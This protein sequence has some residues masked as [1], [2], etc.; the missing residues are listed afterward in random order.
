M[1]RDMPMHQRLNKIGELLA[2]GAYL[3]IQKQKEE[4][5][6]NETKQENNIAVDKNSLKKKKEKSPKEITPSNN[7]LSSLPA[8]TRT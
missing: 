4:A 5:K 7:A 6:E 2:K 1:Y 8:S 3:Y